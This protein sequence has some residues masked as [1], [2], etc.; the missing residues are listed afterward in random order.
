MTSL[1][2]KEATASCSFCKDVWTKKKRKIH[3]KR[4]KKG[5]KNMHPRELH[6]AVHITYLTSFTLK[7]EHKE[8]NM[9]SKNYD[10]VKAMRSQTSDCI[11]SNLS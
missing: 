6:K 8:N 5:K 3:F 2:S 7:K 10:V 4:I 11:T 1:P 9:L